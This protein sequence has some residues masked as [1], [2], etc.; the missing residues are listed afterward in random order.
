MNA[1]LLTTTI[2]GWTQMTVAE[3]RKVNGVYDPD[4]CP[5]RE[6]PRQQKLDDSF[7]KKTML[8]K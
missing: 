1:A 2:D 4:G 3:R 7:P 8:K 6:P 5:Y